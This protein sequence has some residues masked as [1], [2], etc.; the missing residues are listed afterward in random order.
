MQYILDSVIA[1]LQKNPDRT[2]VFGE[3]SYFSRWWDEQDPDTK[4]LVRH[5]VK[6]GQ[7]SF[8]NGG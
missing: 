1:S 6:R 2:F 5:L 3:V 4:R 8:V 7:L